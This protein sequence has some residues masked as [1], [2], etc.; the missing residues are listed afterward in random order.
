MCK[1]K[2]S[3]PNLMKHNKIHCLIC[4]IIPVYNI[5]R[6]YNLLPLVLCTHHNA[7]EWN[8]YKLHNRSYWQ[9][10]CYIFIVGNQLWTGDFVT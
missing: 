5:P 4:F 8:P 2:K 3:V 6:K 10:Y 9:L 1:I 7:V